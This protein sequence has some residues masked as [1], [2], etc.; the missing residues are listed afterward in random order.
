MFSM[1]G[2]EVSWPLAF[3]LCIIVDTDYLSD[4][5]QLA[6]DGIFRIVHHLPIS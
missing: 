6:L 1:F 4:N 5:M 3:N 2:L